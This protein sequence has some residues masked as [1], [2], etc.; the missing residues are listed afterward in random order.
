MKIFLRETDF[1]PGNEK[2][3]SSGNGFFSETKFFFISCA[4]G[5]LRTFVIKNFVMNCI[6]NIFYLLFS[7][8]SDQKNTCI[9]FVRVPL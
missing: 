4:P 2:N 6:E 1:F 8:D 3:I 9:F 7:A 5:K